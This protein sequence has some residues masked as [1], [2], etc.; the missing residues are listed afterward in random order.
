MTLDQIEPIS[1]SLLAR[2]LDQ[3][4]AFRGS[5]GFLQFCIGRV[6]TGLGNGANTSAIPS[7][8]AE[9]SKSHNRGLLVCIEG[10]MVAF[11]TF[12]SYWIDFGSFLRVTLPDC[13][14]PGS[15]A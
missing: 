2:S 9:C 7:W 10:S 8:V 1:L 11:G 13:G 14:R 5:K 6:I 15:R 3:V 12:I 4:T